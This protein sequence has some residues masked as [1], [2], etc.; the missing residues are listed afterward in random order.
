MV[1]R[2]GIMWASYLTESDEMA[3][4][5]AQQIIDDYDVMCSE[6][7]DAS[8]ANDWFFDMCHEHGDIKHEGHLQVVTFEDSSAIEFNGGYWRV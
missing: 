2:L 1:L 7:D 4:T 5:I 3:S 6:C 8:E